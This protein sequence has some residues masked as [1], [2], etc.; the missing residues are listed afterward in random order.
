MS[1]VSIIVPVYNAGR[2]LAPLAESVLTQECPLPLQ[3]IFSDDGSTDASLAQM[4]QLARGDSRITVVS[5]PNMGVSAARNRG[6]QAAVGDYI[7]FADADDRLEPGYVSTLLSLLQQTKADC[8]CCGFIRCYEASGKEEQL[9]LAGGSVAC[10]DRDGFRRLL[11]R[12]DGYTTVV[13]NKLFRKEVLQ[14]DD[15]QWIPFDEDLHIVE[16]GEYLFRSKVQRAVFTPQPLYRYVVRNSGAMYGRLTERK[17][18]E[19][20]ARRRIV[21]LC[22][23]AAPD[24]QELAKMKYQKGV[25]DLLFHGVIGGQAGEIREL[26]P[27]L[28]CYRKELFQSPALSRKDKLKYLCYGA[29]I[30]LRLRRLGAYLMKKFGGH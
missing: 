8:A 18:T 9:P 1:G 19:L 23:S 25:R 12:P 28:R 6:L 27:E 24:V 29:I 16:D 3:L 13:W 15:R 26:L 30:R 2:L 14:N 5:G 11:L 4:Q 21:V 17:K 10:T 22:E 7:G 20:D